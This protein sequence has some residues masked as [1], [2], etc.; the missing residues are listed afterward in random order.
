MKKTKDVVLKENNSNEVSTFIQ[1]AIE[2][3]LPVET[4]ERLFSLREKVKAEQA[5]ELFDEAMSKFQGDCP[6]IKKTKDGAK[7]GGKVVYRYA[8]LDSI[9][10]QTKEF[11]KENGFSYM[12]KTETKEGKGVKVYCIVKHFAGHSE[13]SDIEVPLGSKTNLMSDTQVVA[14]AIT[15]AK[16]YSFCNAFGILTGDEDDDANST[17]E[18]K[19]KPKSNAER[20]EIVIN[21]ETDIGV[22][23]E[24]DLKMKDSKIYKKEEKK[25]LQFLIKNKISKLEA[26]DEN[27]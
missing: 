7:V 6:V 25:H 9:V 3:N 26:E 13:I 16:R 21:K 5:K 14:S 10:S 18:V 1:Q 22:L 23:I 20:M 17:K 27:L 24:F 19:E 2:Q 8:P 12:I 11:L 4:L 15:F